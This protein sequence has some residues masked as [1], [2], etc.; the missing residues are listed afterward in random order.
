MKKIS[1]VIPSYNSAWCLAH[2]VKSCQEQKYD[3]EIEIVVV[4]DASTDSTPELVAF[5][6]AN[7]KRIVS[8]RNSKN[9]GRSMSRNRGNLASTGDIICVL[10]ADDLAYPRRA[11]L[12]AAK[13]KK[14]ADVVY[15]SVEVI[16]AVGLR[17]G[18]IQAA[19]FDK[20]RGLKDKTWGIVH[21]SLA[22]RR[23]LAQDFP[24]SD[25]DVAALGIDDWHLITRLAMAGKKFAHTTEIL[26]AYRLLSGSISRTRD[27]KRVEEVKEK[28][29][30]TLTVPA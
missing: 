11:E 8:L 24:Y 19:E 17:K 30:G 13:I 18:E 16:D 3:G 22:L 20:E 27:E 23:D 7:D 1:F 14:G 9:L 4:D 29:L 15:G 25:G 28:L 5:L 12:T 6:A 10:D 2:A 21:S 26:G